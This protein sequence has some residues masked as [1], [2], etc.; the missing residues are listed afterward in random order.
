MIQ[1][2]KTD[3][4]W[5]KLCKGHYNEKY[6]YTGKWAN[7][8][9]PLFKEIYGW[10]PDEDNNYEDYLVGM[11]NKLLEIHLKIVD[12]RSGSNM[13]IREIFSAAFHKSVSREDDLPIERAISQLC[14]LIQ[15]NTVIENGIPRYEL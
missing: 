9:K 7:T 10:D 6:P 4:Q 5:I 8:L 13:Q 1:L 14:A 12:D 3:K 2:G 15:C 11:F